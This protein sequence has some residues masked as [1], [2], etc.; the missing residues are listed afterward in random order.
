MHNYKVEKKNLKWIEDNL[1]PKH[2]YVWVSAFGDTDAES[3]RSCKKICGRLQGLKQN[4]DLQGNKASGSS[5]VLI[6]PHKSGVRYRLNLI[7]RNI[8]LNQTYKNNEQREMWPSGRW[9]VCDLKSGFA[10][11]QQESS[12][13]LQPVCLPGD[14]LCSGAKGVRAY[15]HCTC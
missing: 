15:I 8:R 11:Q 13:C 7:F 6:L 14:M 5:R 2:W 1:S 10:E 9:A 3:N 4:V 12:V